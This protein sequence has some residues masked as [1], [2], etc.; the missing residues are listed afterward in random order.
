M[1]IQ[2]W[3]R[4]ASEVLREAECPDPQT[5][6]RWIAEDTLSMSST[7]LSFEA[8]QELE[9]ESL[10]R[11]NERLRRRAQGEPVQYILESAYF[12]GQ[13]FYVDQRVLIPRQD[14][15]TLVESII[16]ALRQMSSE[17]PEVLDLCTG[18]GAVGLSVKTLVPQARVT[19]TDISRDALEVARRNAHL[20]NAEAEIRHGDL[21]QAVGKNQYDLIASNP[22]YIPHG[23]LPMLQREVRREPAIAL[24]G[25]QDGL[26]FY[27]RLTAEAAAHLKPAGFLFLEVGMG[28]AEAVLKMT[29]ESIE[30]SQA[31]VIND[32]NGIPRV[33]WAR[34][35]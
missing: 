12:M 9:A 11:L 33:V 18:S 23:D 29:V 13:R 14:T 17:A 8:N 34:S 19:L 24:D 28:E 20:L 27:R 25:G 5:D 22:P 32:L 4:H 7:E 16:V 31:G 35:V 3:L 30:S 10:E 15:E 21:F 6:S 26:D 1:N 2:D